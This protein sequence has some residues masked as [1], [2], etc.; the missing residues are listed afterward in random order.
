V[1]V[2]SVCQLYGLMKDSESELAAALGEE[3][4]PKEKEKKEATTPRRHVGIAE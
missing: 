4:E 1:E 3:P 2:F